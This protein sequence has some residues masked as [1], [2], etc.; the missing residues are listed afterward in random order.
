MRNGEDIS[1]KNV[2]LI[3]IFVELQGL[4]LLAAV[5]KGL[6]DGVI[7][8]TIGKCIHFVSALLKIFRQPLN[9]SEWLQVDEVE[10]N[11]CEYD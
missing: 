11:H 4:S 3:V 6:E 8:G 1:Y 9:S 10:A 7:D 5:K 2:V